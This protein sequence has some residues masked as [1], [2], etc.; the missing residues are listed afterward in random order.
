MSDYYALMVGEG[1]GCDY[2]IG[3]N[4]TF[5]KMKAHNEQDALKEAE[6]LCE[7]HQGEIPLVSLLVLE[8]HKAH[9]IPVKDIYRK[10]DEE[11]RK[12]KEQEKEKEERKELER[13]KAKF[14]S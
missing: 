1:E 7:E 10:M 5:K 14:G 8:V 2:T 3:C 12:E 13:L 11:E 6:Q 4:K 9:Q